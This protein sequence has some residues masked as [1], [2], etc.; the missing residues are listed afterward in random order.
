MKGH[1]RVPSGAQEFKENTKR[2]ALNQLQIELDKLRETAPED[3]RLGLKDQ[4]DAFAKLFERFL[5]EEGPSIDWNKI[6]KLP[7]GAV[8]VVLIFYTLCIAK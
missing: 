2:D 7:T 1:Q 6:E 4:Y 5:Q 8:S 3:K